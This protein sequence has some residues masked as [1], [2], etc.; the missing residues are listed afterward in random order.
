MRY[1]IRSEDGGR[2]VDSAATVLVLYVSGKSWLEESSIIV[3][4]RQGKN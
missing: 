2:E 1:M 3:A 4:K